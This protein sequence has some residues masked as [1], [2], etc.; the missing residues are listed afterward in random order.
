MLLK[1]IFEIISKMNKS[2]KSFFNRY[3]K[4]YSNNT[5]NRSYLLIY[6][7]IHKQVKQKAF[8]ERK[9]LKI[10]HRK[11]DAKYLTNH[12]QYL[13]QQLRYSLLNPLIPAK[14]RTAWSWS[15]FNV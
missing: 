15:C 1:E 2:E 13:H 6:E 4:L 10:I 12:T 9:L 14:N 7:E 5:M 11:I 3:C 8:D